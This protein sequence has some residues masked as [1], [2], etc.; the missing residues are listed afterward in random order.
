[1]VYRYDCN[2][3]FNQI[4]LGSYQLALPVP[5][6]R[7]TVISGHDSDLHRP[8]NDF[9]RSNSTFLNPSQWQ[10]LKPA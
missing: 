4:R 5:R 10:G 2:G 8:N 7:F 6:M 9:Q 1:M 3:F